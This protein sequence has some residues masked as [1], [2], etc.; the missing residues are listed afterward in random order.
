MVK[1]LRQPPQIKI[2]VKELLENIDNRTTHLS[3]VIWSSKTSY[4]WSININDI[5]STDF[6]TECIK[7][8]GDKEIAPKGIKFIGFDRGIGLDLILK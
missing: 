1:R 3:I 4:F 7:K 2:K 5:Y 8:Y 6:I